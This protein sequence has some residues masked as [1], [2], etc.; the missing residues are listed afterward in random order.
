MSF[1]DDRGAARDGRKTTATR[2]VFTREERELLV[3]LMTRHKAVIENK[4][5]DALAKRAKD[6]AWEKLMSE[7]NSQPG[8]RRVKPKLH[9]RENARDSAE[10]RDVD[11]RRA[12]SR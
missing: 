7:Y 8:I 12:I 5:T 1:K 9:K 3:S 10:R 11:R 6:S 2:F 4:R